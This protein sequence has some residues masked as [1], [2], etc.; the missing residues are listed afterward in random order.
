MRL[1]SNHIHMCA[2]GVMCLLCACETPDPCRGDATCSA[3]DAAHSES[4]ST[5]PAEDANNN[6]DD[7]GISAHDAGASNPGC[8]A[9]LTLRSIDGTSTTIDFCGGKR[10]GADVDYRLG[11][12]PQVAVTTLRLDASATPGFE[13]FI[14]VEFRGVCDS[15]YYYSD[16]SSYYTDDSSS[17]R[18]VT[19]DCP[20]VPNS[21]LGDF[22]T[23]DFS[24]AS[25]YFRV[26]R[27]ESNAALGDVP[28]TTFQMRVAG[29]LYF[30]IV[31]PITGNVLLSVEGD[32][33]VADIVGGSDVDGLRCRDP[34]LDEC[35][36]F[37]RP[38]TASD[39]CIPMLDEG[40][41]V[42]QCY[43]AGTDEPGQSCSPGSC[44]VGSVCGGD[45]AGCLVLCDNRAVNPSLVCPGGFACERI[46]GGFF[47]LGVGLCQ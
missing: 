15:G 43:P 22:N 35:H 4:D 14:E 29:A 8:R 23:A 33:D 2:L 19:L 12:A 6:L 34:L 38:C 30:S 9:D 26:D 32:F 11:F 5:A 46:G 24:D 7:A 45:S 17:A 21:V 41:L 39:A 13:C 16:G 44:V 20:G 31:S 3:R 18:I 25:S 27:I 10:L 47:H 37:T 1:I 42:F 36:P 40:R 28:G